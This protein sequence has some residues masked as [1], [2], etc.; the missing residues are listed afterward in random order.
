MLW[1]LYRWVGGEIGGGGGG[2]VL[3]P[4]SMGRP[5]PWLSHWSGWVGGWM[6]GWVEKR[7]EIEAVRMRCCKLRRRLVGVR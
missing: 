2:L 1:V 5:S 4:T 6:G 3:G 7:E